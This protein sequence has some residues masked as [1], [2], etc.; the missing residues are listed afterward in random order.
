MPG[1]LADLVMLSHDIMRV[2][3]REILEA[4]VLMTV[5]GGQIVFDYRGR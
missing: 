2:E 4:R 5:A 1:K 3:P